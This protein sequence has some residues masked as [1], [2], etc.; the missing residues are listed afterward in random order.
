MIFIA[1]RGQ[2]MKEILLAHLSMAF[3]GSYHFRNSL[4]FKY[5]KLLITFELLTSLFKILTAYQE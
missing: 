5:D 3:E 1:G 4:L 2:Q